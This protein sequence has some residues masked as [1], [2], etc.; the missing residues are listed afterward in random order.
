[1]HLLELKFP[2]TFLKQR[3]FQLHSRL[4]YEKETNNL[5]FKI[6]VSFDFYNTFIASYASESYFDYGTINVL[7]LQPYHMEAL[8]HKH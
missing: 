1:M 3:H 2:T 6:L 5:F 4:R 7:R 8:L